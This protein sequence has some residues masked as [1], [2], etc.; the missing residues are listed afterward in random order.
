[1]QKPADAT[2]RSF[3]GDSIPQPSQA[4]KFDRVS[5]LE[6]MLVLRRKKESAA[7]EFSFVTEEQES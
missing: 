6:Q 3:Q 2:I 4:D 5:D 1:M 7:S